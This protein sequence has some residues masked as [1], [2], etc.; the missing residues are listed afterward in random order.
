MAM[1]ALQVEKVSKNFGGIRAINGIDLTIEIGERRGIIGPNGAG[2]TTLFNLISGLTQVSSGSISLF[3]TDI[4]H[5]PARKRQGLGL[6]R[7]FQITE[8]FPRLTVFNN[9]LLGALSLDSAR[10]SLLRSIRSYK[11]LLAD[12]QE[13]LSRWGLWEK[14]DM[15]VSS[16]SYG[17]RRQLELVVALASKPRFLLLDEPTAGLGTAETQA[18]CSMI[19]ALGKEI[20]LLIIEHDINAAIQLSEKAT[21]LNFGEIIA[22]GS[23][24]QIRGDSHVWEIYLGLKRT[25]PF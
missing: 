17:E 19:Q 11:R 8:L 15:A 1:K 6:G 12:G 7:T 16:L 5:M 10:F 21:V 3:G 9:V 14:R 18:M 22:E 25:W 4:S 23:W 13:L 2:K 24:D 20:T